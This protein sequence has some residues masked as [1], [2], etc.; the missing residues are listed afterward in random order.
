MISR[1][2]A[3]T[4]V[5]MPLVFGCSSGDGENGDRPALHLIGPA[6]AAVV[7]EVDPEARFFEIN[8]TVDGVNLFI[9]V[10]NVDV[11]A[12]PGTYG[13]VQARFTS[14]DGLVVSKDVLPA[15]GSVF[16]AGDVDFVPESITRSVEEELPSSRARALIM[17]ATDLPSEASDGGTALIDYTI[18][19]ESERGGRLMVHVSRDGAILGSDLPD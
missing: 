18:V 13:V 10:P 11:A 5:L 3:V 2:S 15:Q 9:A 16:R 19:M 7:A 6:I 4:C 1:I 17:T 14:D 12:Q 8:A